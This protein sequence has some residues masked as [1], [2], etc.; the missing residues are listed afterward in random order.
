MSAALPIP[1]LLIAPEKELSFYVALAEL[2][3]NG[4]SDPK[5]QALI[6]AIQVPERNAELAERPTEKAAEHS[7]EQLKKLW[8][9]L[10]EARKDA[11]G[12]ETLASADFETF[13]RSALARVFTVLLLDLALLETVGQGISEFELLL[14]GAQLVAKIQRTE[15][16]SRSTE[17]QG[18]D[19]QSS[20][21]VER[22]G[23]EQ[24]AARLREG[25][26]DTLVY[27]HDGLK[28]VQVP[29]EQTPMPSRNWILMI[30]PTLC[31]TTLYRLTE[32]GAYR[33][34]WFADSN[35]YR[36]DDQG[37]F[38]IK[39]WTGFQRFFM[40]NMSGPRT[41]VFV[42]TEQ[43]EQL[44][45]LLRHKII[46]LLN[47]KDSK[48]RKLDLE[49]WH[50][51]LIQEV[52]LSSHPQPSQHVQNTVIGYCLG[53]LGLVETEDEYLDSKRRSSYREYLRSHVQSLMKRK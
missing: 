10:S 22:I 24:V 26:L 4:S 21:I 49:Q 43:S 28:F 31:R 6:D 45:Q 47:R 50:A 12:Y 41:D 11:E 52:L 53:L 51:M 3:D 23:Q 40:P 25:T 46:L 17:I 29:V 39:D 1:H 30:E 48:Q 27:H 16:V 37:V 34:Y 36:V 33:E 2:L 9:F 13:R 14:G 44:W 5:A 15:T 35:Q 7:N 20:I 32:D 19:A 42:P 18:I 8:A 38:Q